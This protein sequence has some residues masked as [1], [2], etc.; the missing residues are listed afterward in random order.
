MLRATRLRLGREL[1]EIAAILRI[2]LSYLQALEDGDAKALP[3]TTYAIGFVRAYADYL[4]LDSNEVVRRFKA[5]VNATHH[6][7]ELVFPAPVP[8]SGIPR[9]AVL[10]MALVIAGAAYG[11]WYY[12]SSVDKRVVDLVS[13][14]S[15]RLMSLLDRTEAPVRAP[16]RAAAVAAETAPG[17]RLALVRGSTSGSADPEIMRPAPN[18]SGAVEPGPVPESA[19]VVASAP[20]IHSPGNPAPEV[21]EPEARSVDAAEVERSAAEAAP[22]TEAAAGAPA[23]DPSI[24]DPA[25]TVSD[26]PALP[27][28]RAEAE[29]EVASLPGPNESAAAA[30][31]TPAA[32]PAGVN[33][34][35]PAPAPVSIETAQSGQTFGV[36]EDRARIVLRARDDAWVQV[37]DSDNGLVLTRMLRAGDVYRVPPRQGLRLITG[38]AGALEVLV[39]GKATPSLGALGMVRRNV[40]LDADRLLAGVATN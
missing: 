14:P 31:A 21:P 33:A 20:E 39:D 10:L 24:Q 19:A 28:R 38:N 2:R 4:G 27:A 6:R 34:I 25:V 40:P 36:A 9:G 16:D 17:E 22:R 30:E 12:L 3:G 32:E 18:V 8:D 7:T 5:E 1:E 29:A 23:Q 13:E 26:I 11:G 15:E 37:R 35:P